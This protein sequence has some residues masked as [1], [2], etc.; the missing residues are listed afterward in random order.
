[1]SS[2][3]GKSKSNLNIEVL[4]MQSKKI[5]QDLDRFNQLVESLIESSALEKIEFES[6]VARLENENCS[7]RDNLDLT[8]RNFVQFS[9]E[10][11]ECFSEIQTCLCLS[12]VDLKTIEN[13]NYDEVLATSRENMIMIKDS[14]IKKFLPNDSMDQ[15][16]QPI[17][18]QTTV[19][20]SHFA[21]NNVK[22]I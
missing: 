3:L 12:D 21:Q 11:N 5:Q 14:I 19:D 20:T 22:I 15:Q 4:R 16:S 13:T 6:R 2:V 17:V 18:N 7:I 9:F 1:M 10:Q 8:F